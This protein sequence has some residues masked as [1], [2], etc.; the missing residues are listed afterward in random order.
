[1]K[2]SPSLYLEKFNSDS[3]ENRCDHSSGTARILYSIAYKH[4]KHIKM[5]NQLFSQTNS[6]R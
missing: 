5:F 2:Y 4:H 6:N 3:L 1:M